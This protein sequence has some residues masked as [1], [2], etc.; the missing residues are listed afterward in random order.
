MLPK[1]MSKAEAI[2]RLYNHSTPRGTGFLHYDSE[3]M[4]ITEA[5]ILAK[6]HYLDYYRGRVMKINVSR[7][8]TETFRLYD[9]DNGP[10]AAWEALT[11]PEAPL[12]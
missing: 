6:E 5:E 4:T 1:G 9:R 8:E 7:L 10:G 3:P 2:A 12:P 11:D